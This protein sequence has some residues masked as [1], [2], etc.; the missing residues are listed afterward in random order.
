MQ[1]F[2]NVFKMAHEALQLNPKGVEWRVHMAMVLFAMGERDQA[3]AQFDQ[4]L[5][6]DPKNEEALRFRNMVEMMGDR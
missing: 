5:A 4:A 3:I 2:E 6:I 1:D